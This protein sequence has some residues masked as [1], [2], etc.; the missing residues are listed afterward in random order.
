MCNLQKQVLFISPLLSN[1]EITY[2]LNTGIF[3]RKKKVILNT[4]FSSPNWK[5]SH[6]VQH[7]PNNPDSHFHYCDPW[8]QL[9]DTYLL[10]K[11][12]GKK[13]SCSQEDAKSFYAYIIGKLKSLYLGWRQF[14]SSLPVKIFLPLCQKKAMLKNI[15]NAQGFTSSDSRILN[16]ES[17]Q[18]HAK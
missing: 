18:M 3:F 10:R 4:L 8:V 15:T 2:V 12:E 13:N 7:G 5:Q 1:D 16:P 6:V 9:H 11:K 17:C 14:P